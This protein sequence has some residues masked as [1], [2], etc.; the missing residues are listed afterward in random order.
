MF[1]QCANPD[2]KHSFDFRFGRVM[3]FHNNDN[4]EGLAATCLPC[5][6]HFWLCEHCSRTHVLE[7]EP[8][9]GVVIKAR[10]GD[11]PAHP[12]ARPVC[13]CPI[14]KRSVCYPG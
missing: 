8:G 13:D 1:S 4:P 3:R 12:A 11:S 2:C 14:G 5:V 6:R 7:H 9:T 10:S